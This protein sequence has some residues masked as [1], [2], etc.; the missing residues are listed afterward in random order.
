MCNFYFSALDAPM[1]NRMFPENWK[2]KENSNYKN[3]IALFQKTYS[4]KLRL[5]FHHANVVIW[6]K[7]NLCSWFL[8][9][10][11]LFPFFKLLLFFFLVCRSFF[12]KYLCFQFSVFS[13]NF[14]SS[15][16]S[17]TF[18]YVIFGDIYDM[19]SPVHQSVFFINVVVCMYIYFK[20]CLVLRR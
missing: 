12:Q 2:G 3:K 7:N 9:V 4:T 16:I 17:F 14:F 18:I 10:L 11:F 15:F 6:K 20:R 13:Y 5:N 1:L 8:C 19:C